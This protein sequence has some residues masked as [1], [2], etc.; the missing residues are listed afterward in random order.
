MIR[1]MA[2]HRVT[3]VLTPVLVATLTLVAPRFVAAP[4]AA[5]QAEAP[6][7]VAIGDIHGAYEQFV[8]I[9]KAA[10]L[11]DGQLRWAGGR[12]TFVQTGD[13]LD[14]GARARDVLDLLMRLE[15][16]AKRGGGR[17]EIL[18]GNHEA[19]NILTEFRDVS[20]DVFKSFADAESEDRRRRAFDDYAKTPSG[21]GNVGSTAGRD[22][23]MQSHPPGFLEYVE[24]IGPR[25]K[26]GKWLRARKVVQNI[27]GSIFMHA[28][29]PP[30]T[31]GS[32]EDVNRTV[33]RDIASWDET[34]ESMVRASLAQPYFTLQET[35]TAAALELERIGAALKAGT[36]PGGHVTREF[37][38][39][40]QAVVEIG[41]SSLVTPNG[42]LWF[43]GPAKWTD[44]DEPQVKSMLDRF[45]AVRVVTAH[46]PMLPGRI[47]PHV[48]NRVFLIDTGMN[49]DFFKNGRPSALEIQGDRI[50]AIYTTERE[51][52][53]PAA[54]GQPAREPARPR[55]H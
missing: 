17:A 5:R 33:S 29:L 7:I 40:L 23:W 18:L 27:N 44:A 22:A 46:T 14:R 51:V 19:M 54:G 49:T 9:L 35:V 11:I 3:L 10:G 39:R 16:E 6:R 45:G 48:G 42:P 38:T 41:K 12:T 32:L 8:E 53:V 50:T 28:G 4:A 31:T 1:P 43:R 25:G 36:D 34:K 55:S 20:P 30:D 13:Y 52:L 21:R 47:A 2:L 15:D 37:A 26:Y 24:A